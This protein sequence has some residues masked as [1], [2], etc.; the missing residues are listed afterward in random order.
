[1]FF[2]F[3]PSI[4]KINTVETNVPNDFTRKLPKI[5]FGSTIFLSKWLSSFVCVFLKHSIYGY[6]R[7][8]KRTLTVNRITEEGQHHRNMHRCGRYRFNLGFYKISHWAYCHSQL[9][10]GVGWFSVTEHSTTG[11]LVSFKDYPSHSLTN[12]MPLWITLTFT[13]CAFQCVE[14]LRKVF[15][16]FNHPKKLFKKQENTLLS[17]LYDILGLIVLKVSFMLYCLVSVLPKSGKMALVI[18]V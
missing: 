2:C 14:I 18:L 12:R 9:W 5:A 6:H 1:M 17:Y 11:C 3:F 7:Q 13:G 16:F 10:S 8:E 4:Q 15:L